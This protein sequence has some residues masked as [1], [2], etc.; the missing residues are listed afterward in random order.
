MKVIVVIQGLFFALTIF[1]VVCWVINI[2]VLF[3]CDFKAPY[4][5][6]AIHA[7]GLIPYAGIITAWDTN[8]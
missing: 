4:K 1:M 7:I 6:E 2:R 8:R 3:S 5:G